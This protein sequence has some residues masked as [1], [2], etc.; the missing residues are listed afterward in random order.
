[1][2]KQTTELR[3]AYERLLEYVVQNLA[4]RN[5]AKVAKNV[6]LHENTVRSIANG[7]NKNPAIE[8]LEKLADYLAGSR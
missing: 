3:E 6:R 1:M 2:P 8:T 7:N 4:D 5:L